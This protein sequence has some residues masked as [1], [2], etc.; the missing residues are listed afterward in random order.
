MKQLIYKISLL[1]VIIIVIFA[2]IL[3][4]VPPQFE[5]SY[6]SVIKD[7]YDNLIKTKSPKIIFTGGSSG[8]FGL[9]E[10][11]LSAKT[12]MPVVNLA[13]H[14]GMG[15]KFQTELT[16]AN[17]QK[18]DIVILGY[19]YGGWNS[20]DNFGADL[21]VTG[22]EDKK[23]MYG[24]IPQT[25]YKDVAKYIPKYV[26]RKLGYYLGV[27]PG[28]KSTYSKSSFKDGK[29]IL[30]RPKCT[31]SEPINE[32]NYGAAKISR[33]IISDEAIEYV[34]SFNQYVISKGATLLVTFP[35]VLNEQVNDSDA[36]IIDFKKCLIDKL[37]CPVISD[38]KPYMFPREYMFDTIYHCNNYGEKMRTEL[39]AEDIN[40]YLNNSI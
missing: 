30:D 32:K 14:A 27:Y 29:M 5:Q 39:L 34:N 9:D 36:N 22:I 15:M 7:K 21:I 23:E 11:L 6:Q 31:L 25:H 20:I 35:P 10:D 13:L 3:F 16:K 1:T 24:Y 8:A 19:E 4:A 12:G 18:D 38:V 28:A 37:D 2:L 17:I 40:K 26:G 33:S